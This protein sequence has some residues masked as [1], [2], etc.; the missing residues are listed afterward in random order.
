M[1]ALQL[2]DNQV[3]TNRTQM[4]QLCETQFQST[5]IKTSGP[6][7]AI[8]FHIDA[9]LVDRNVLDA[10]SETLCKFLF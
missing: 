7:A 8:Y 1:N 6:Y 3:A 2:Y 10:C 5:V 9:S 4:L